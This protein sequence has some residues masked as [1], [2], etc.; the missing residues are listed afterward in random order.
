MPRVMVQANDEKGVPALAKRKQLLGRQRSVIADDVERED[1]EARELR[2]EQFFP[3]REA[4]QFVAGRPILPVLFLP[5]GWK[6]PPFD[7][8]QPG[9]RPG[10]WR[11][12]E[13][14]TLE[15]AL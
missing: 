2:S 6:A 14:K 12:D 9:V 7:I 15:R 11:D 13:I 8:D 10:M 1:Q 4:L 5:A 3:A